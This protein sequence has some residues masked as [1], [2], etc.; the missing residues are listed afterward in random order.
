MGQKTCCISLMCVQP[1][2]VFQN[3]YCGVGKQ[4]HM[5]FVMQKVLVLLY[6]R[7]TSSFMTF[8]LHLLSSL[9]LIMVS[10]LNTFICENEN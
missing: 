4:I 3:M 10:Y 2:E 8:L 1:L 9:N 6:E 5:V 7:M